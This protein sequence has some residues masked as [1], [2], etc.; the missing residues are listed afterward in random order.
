MNVRYA[1]SFA[2]A[3]LLYLIK[4]KKLSLTTDGLQM[5][6]TGNGRYLEATVTYVYQGIL[7][8]RD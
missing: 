3:K 1:Q 5:Y 6:V 4:E 2:Q 7:S 8:V